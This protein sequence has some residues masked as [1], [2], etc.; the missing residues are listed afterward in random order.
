MT[1]PPNRNLKTFLRI[2][3]QLRVTAILLGLIQLMDT[4]F[5]KSNAI[6][7]TSLS[8]ILLLKGSCAIPEREGNRNLNREVW[9]SPVQSLTITGEDVKYFLMSDS[10]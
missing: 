4:S 8:L 7:P 1:A 10:L 6:S 9:E 3:D 2:F 5:K